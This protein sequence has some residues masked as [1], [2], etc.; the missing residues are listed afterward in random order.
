MTGTQHRKLRLLI[1]GLCLAALVGALLPAQADAALAPRTFPKINTCIIR[2]GPSANATVI[3]QMEDGTAV[4][5]L[6]QR[7]GYYK[8]DC[9]DMTG[10]IAASQVARRP[11][12]EYYIDCDPASEHTAAIDCTGV[13]DAL[14]L[15]A[16][17]L[18]LARKHLGTPYVYGGA[19]PGAFD[20]SGLTWYV[21]GKNGYDIRRGAS[22]QMQNSLIVS[23]DGLQVGDL[24]FFR[25]AGSPYLA[26]HVG[27]Y[28]GDGR[29]IHAGNSGVSYG[30]LNDPWFTENYLCARRIITVSAQAISAAP[31]GAAQSL[32]GGNYGTGI[33]TAKNLP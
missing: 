32:L 10:Y 7:S 15:R 9:Y 11:T 3:G 31:S 16:G 2:N 22:A 18:S 12:G 24:I 1:L 30:D 5:V 20:C 6:G 25:T 13:A 27:I 17:V 33:R 21:F 28:A 26:S 29:I 8:I 4:T 19:R 23:R 14:L